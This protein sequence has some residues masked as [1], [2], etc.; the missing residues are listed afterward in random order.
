[1]ELKQNVEKCVIL[2]HEIYG[3]NQHIRYYA[4]YFF[5]NGYDVYIPNLLGKDVPYSYENEEVAYHNFN[6]NIGF[7]AVL[8]QI[9]K[10]IRDVEQSYNKIQIVGFSIGATVGWL[11]SDEPSIQK[12]IGFYGSRIR[13]YIEIEP[14]AEVVLLY[15]DKEKSF[16]PK[17]LKKVLEQK[18]NVFI[19]IVEAE[20][21]FA[22]PFSSKYQE[23]ITK[24]IIE[25]YLL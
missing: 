16:E 3:I 25:R 9:K 10:L 23:E 13:Q 12:V 6:Q 8:Q 22:D 20:H 15:G 2:L 4:D 17:E 21:G 19:E 14:K 18:S 11:C 7:D 1:M 24:H 5:Q